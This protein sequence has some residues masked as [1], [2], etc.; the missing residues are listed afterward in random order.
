M[1]WAIITSKSAWISLIVTE[2][3]LLEQNEHFF[4]SLFAHSDVV[5]VHAV[6]SP[7]AV[8][9]VNGK[10]CMPLRAQNW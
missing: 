7:R 4:S 3:S 2:V 6:Y 5:Y 10:Q 1:V 8:K 9:E